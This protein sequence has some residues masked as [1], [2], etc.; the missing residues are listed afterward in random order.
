MFV[1]WATYRSMGAAERSK[2]CGD[3]LLAREGDRSVDASGFACRGESDGL[4]GA[5][6]SEVS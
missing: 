6:M 3:A 4:D 5:A 1:C 2:R